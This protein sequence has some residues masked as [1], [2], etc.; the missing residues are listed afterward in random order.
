MVHG[1][2]FP[3]E[4]SDCQVTGNQLTDLKQAHTLAGVHHLCQLGQSQPRCGRLPSDVY[5]EPLMRAT[6]FGNAPPLRKIC[7]AILPVHCAKGF[8]QVQHTD[9]QSLAFVPGPVPQKAQAKQS[10]NCAPA[11]SEAALLIKKAVCQPL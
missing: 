11:W 3:I 9:V 6:C 1:C 8:G 7:Q 4:R 5:G 2:N 10:V